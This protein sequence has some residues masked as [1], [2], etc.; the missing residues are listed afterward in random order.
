MN[1]SFQ[2]WHFFYVKSLKKERIPF[3]STPLFS[4]SLFFLSFNTLFSFQFFNG[5]HAF[6][7]SIVLLIQVVFCWIAL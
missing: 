6:Y 7:L 1:W 5:S 2:I 4:F 3:H